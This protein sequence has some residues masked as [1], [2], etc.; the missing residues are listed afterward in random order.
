MGKIG[1]SIGDLKLGLYTD[2][3]HSSGVDHTKSTSRVIMALEGTETWFPLA[4]ASRRQ[5]ATACSVT[6]AE[7]ISLGAGLFREGIPA[8][9]LC[10][11]F[12]SE[13]RST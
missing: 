12:F 5:T 6:E 1:N 7:K 10:E 11:T 8:Q 13:T 4:W 3:D 2:A 9:E